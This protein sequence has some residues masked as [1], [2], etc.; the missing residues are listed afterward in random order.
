MIKA[1]L[2]LAVAILPGLS[3]FGVRV[4]AAQDKEDAKAVFLDQE[5]KVKLELVWISP[6]KFKMGSPD[7]EKD[8]EGREKQHEVTITKGFWMQTT[9]V[10]QAQWEAV[11]GSNPSGFKS[12]PHLPVERVGWDDCREFVNKLNELCKDQLGELRADLPTEAEWEYACRSGSKERWCFG[13]DES[14]L[15]EYAWHNKNSENK[16]H[17][18]GGKKPNAW[19]LYDMHGNVW[20][21]CKDWH[22][23]YGDDAID[24]KGPD[25]GEA[26][27]VRGGSWESVPR[28][29]RAAYRGRGRPSRRGADVGVRVAAR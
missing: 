1:F 3:P 6:G 5:K 19:G 18:V 22:G 8:R 15:E 16:T 7:G 20:E 29:L 28:H 17:P 10:T 14:K 2:L 26:R 13:N 27:T 23:D 25:D 11:M 9:E 21:W 24:P 4:L 12:D